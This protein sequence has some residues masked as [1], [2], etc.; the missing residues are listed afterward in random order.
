[1]DTFPRL[2]LDHAARRPDAPALREKAFGVWQT[3]SWSR[4]AD[5]V[6]LH[7]L[8]LL[9]AARAGVDPDQPRHLSRSIILS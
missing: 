1:M 4:L 9:K 8:C 7:R 5:L 2:L 3:L 6:R